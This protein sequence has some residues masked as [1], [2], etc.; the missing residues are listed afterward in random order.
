MIAIVVV[1][2]IV[3]V[4]VIVLVIVIVIVIVIV[5]VEVGVHLRTNPMALTNYQSRYKGLGSIGSYR[6]LIFFSQVG[7]IWGLR[8]RKPF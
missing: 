1:I 7:P 5:M 3:I 4:I 2:V 6:S 8:W